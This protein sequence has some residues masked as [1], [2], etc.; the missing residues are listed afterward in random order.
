MTKY[1]AVVFDLDGTLLDSLEDLADSMNIVLE[2]C[3]FPTHPIEDYKYFVGDGMYTLVERTVPRGKKWDKKLIEKCFL[4]M[5]KEYSQRWN[6]KTKPYPQ[7]PELLTYLT[8]HGIRM[9]ILSNKPHEF[10]KMIVC[11]LLSDWKFEVVL[12]QRMGVPKKPNPK[13]AFDIAESL[14]LRPEEFL[15]LGDTNVDMKTATRAKMHPIGVLWGFRG[16]EEL[17][18]S[19]AKILIKEPLELLNVLEN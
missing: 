15:Y 10:T 2:K 11:N 4:M 13:G 14:Q 19:G 17:Q 5:K 16:A 6:R 7:I 9:T 18:K 1:K 8:E 12:G 3:G